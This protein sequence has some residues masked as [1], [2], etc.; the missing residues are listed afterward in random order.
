VVPDRPQRVDCLQDQLAV[1]GV[2]G[3][4]GDGT[5]HVEN[6]RM[7]TAYLRSALGIEDAG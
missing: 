2:S 6:Q 3:D 7:T 5:D 4:P 1:A